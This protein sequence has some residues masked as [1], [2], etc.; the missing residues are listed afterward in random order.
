[1]SMM[2]YVVTLDDFYEIQYEHQENEGQD[3]YFISSGN[4]IKLRCT[5]IINNS[6]NQKYTVF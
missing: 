5:T 3:L 2:G 1:M 6:S 4:N